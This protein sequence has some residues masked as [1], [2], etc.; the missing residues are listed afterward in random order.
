MKNREKAS[1]IFRETDYVFS[2]KWSFEEA[3]PDIEDVQV[4]VTESE[5]MIWAKNPETLVYTK[6]HLPGEFINC[7]N[8]LCYSGGVS[9]GEIL[10]NMVRN[11]QT[12]T[13][14]SSKCRGYEGS[15]K[16]KRKSRSCMHHFRIKVELK[17][18][19]A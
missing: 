1:D 19:N 4:E 8:T 14:V 5:D 6:Q 9:V 10:R 18:K 17:Y 16:G 13:E 15:P 11:K 2:K 7:S 3:F 12:E